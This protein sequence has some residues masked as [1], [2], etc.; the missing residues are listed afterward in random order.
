[1]MT[2]ISDFFDNHSTCITVISTLVTI[3]GMITNVLI[4]HFPTRKDGTGKSGKADEYH[5][6]YEQ[7]SKLVST[8]MISKNTACEI[9]N[10]IRQRELWNIRRILRLRSPNG[11]RASRISAYLVLAFSLV[12]FLATLTTVLIMVAVPE[13]SSEIISLTILLLVYTLILFSLSAY[14]LNLSANDEKNAA[15]YDAKINHYILTKNSLD[16]NELAQLESEILELDNLLPGF[17]TQRKKQ[18]AKHSRQ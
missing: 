18:I 10:L 9:H 2:I 17:A 12:F 14:E 3:V 5:A 13:K 1:M 16:E 6:L 8:S 15:D 4:K 11:W 7:V